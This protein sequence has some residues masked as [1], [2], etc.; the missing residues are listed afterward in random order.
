MTGGLYNNITAHGTEIIAKLWR[1]KKPSKK[2]RV[3]LHMLPAY[4]GNNSWF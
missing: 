4:V 1:E 3:G 2:A